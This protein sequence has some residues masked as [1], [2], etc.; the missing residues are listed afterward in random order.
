M[1]PFT[2]KVPPP[3]QASQAIHHGQSLAVRLAVARCCSRS[4][5]SLNST[6]NYLY[7]PGEERR[8][9][10]I[11]TWQSIAAELGDIILDLTI[12]CNLCHHRCHSS[13]RSCPTLDTN[14]WVHYCSHWQQ[15]QGFPSLVIKGVSTQLSVQSIKCWVLIVFPPQPLLQDQIT[16]FTKEI[17]ER[18]LQLKEVLFF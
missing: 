18:E 11:S 12:I 5:I 6:S 4:W 10:Y 16:P 8:V 3:T 13:N 14:F 17:R 2:P 1:T 9:L 15:H 7:Y